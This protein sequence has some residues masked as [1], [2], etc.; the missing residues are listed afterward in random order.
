MPVQCSSCVLH[1]PVL[2]SQPSAKPIIHTLSAPSTAIVVELMAPVA[3]RNRQ[4]PCSRCS[5]SKFDPSSPKN[6]TSDVEVDSA[7]DGRN[8]PAPAIVTARQRLPFQCTK[9]GLYRPLVDVVKPTAQASFLLGAVI[10]YSEV[11]LAVR[12]W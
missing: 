11:T 2:S 6:Q 12:A 1:C 8:A 7:T 9:F 3:A 10:P 5:A 4:R